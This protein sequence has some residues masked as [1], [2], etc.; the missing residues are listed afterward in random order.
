MSEKKLSAGDY[1]ASRCSKCKDVTNHTIVAMVEDKVVR[2][3]CNTCGGTHNYRSAAPKVKTERSKSSSS[4]T[5]SRPAK[6][7]KT[8]MEW[9]AQLNE[10]QASDAIPYSFKTIFK[11]GDLIQ[12]SVFGMGR[13]INT[14]NPNKMEVY[15]RDGVKMLRC[16]LK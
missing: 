10:A 8:E 12:H 14:I 11:T 4:S 5:G 9:A 15:F 13:V 2:V 7:A 16:T 6:V 1:I 3:Q